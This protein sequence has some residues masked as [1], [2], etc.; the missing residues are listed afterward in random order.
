M[1]RPEILKENIKKG[2]IET[3]AELRETFADFADNV[4]NVQPYGN[5][6]AKYKG[7]T[8]IDVWNASI[9]ETSIRK[10]SAEVLDLLMLRNAGFQNIKRDDVSV[11]F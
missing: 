6:E 2:N 1:E 11:R 8:L 5:S 10:A 3:E 9:A 4:Y 7:M